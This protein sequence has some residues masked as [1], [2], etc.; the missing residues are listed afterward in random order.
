MVFELCKLLR[1]SNIKICKI[2]E[3]GPTQRWTETNRPQAAM[4][5]LAL[6]PTWQDQSFGPLRGWRGDA[7]TEPW[8]RVASSVALGFFYM[9]KD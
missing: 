7:V 5:S 9:D 3:I 8:P 4:G 6:P 2:A 1:F